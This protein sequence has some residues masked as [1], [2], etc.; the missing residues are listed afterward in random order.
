MPDTKTELTLVTSDNSCTESVQILRC[1]RIYL[2][3][4]RRS[5]FVAKTQLL[6]FLQLVSKIKTRE[7]KRSQSSTSIIVNLLL[8]QGLFSPQFNQFYTVGFFLQIMFLIPRATPKTNSQLL[9]LCYT[10]F[11]KSGREWTMASI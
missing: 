10:N 8:F 4:M 2:T 5:E 7:A 11:K 1:T 9:M 6:A 3:G